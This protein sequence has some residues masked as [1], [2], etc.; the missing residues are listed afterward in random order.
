MIDV[1]K[2]PKGLV[3]AAGSVWVAN[4]GTRT[5]SRINIET[6]RVV[7]TLEVGNGPTEIAV[8]G[9]LLWVA[10]ATDDTIVSIDPQTDLIGER[11]GIGGSPVALVGDHTGLWV[12]T[13]K[14]V[15]GAR[16]DPSVSTTFSPPIPLSGRPSALALDERFAW[17]ATSDGTVTRIERDTNRV[18]STV[19]IGGRPTAIIATDDSVWVSDEEGGV[20]QLDS[21]NPSMSPRRIST[22][23]PIASLAATEGGILVAA[24]ASTASHR[25][26]TLRVASLERYPT[27]PLAGGQDVT[28]L[29]ADGLTGFRRVG[30]TAGATL[31]PDLAVSIPSPSDSGL[32]YTFQLRPNLTYASGEPIRAGDFRRA[33]E[34]SFY[35]P[36]DGCCWGDILFRA[37]VGADACLTEDL[38]PVETCDLTDGVVTDDRTNTVTFRL[39]KP[40]ADLPYKL[41]V[42]PA[43]PVPE[44]V[45]MHEVVDGPFPGAGPYVVTSTSET[46]VRLGRNP[47]FATWDA[48]VRPDGF[49]DEI[50]FDVIEDADQAIS[51]VGNGDIDYVTTLGSTQDAARQFAIQYPDQWH[52]STVGTIFAIMNTS[53]AP[54]DNVDARRAVS[55]AIDRDRMVELGTGPQGAAVTCQ[56]LPP[57]YPGYEPYCPYTEHPGSGRWEHADLSAARAM[58]DSSGTS[59][60]HVVVGPDIFF[61]KPQ[62][63]YLASVLRDLGYD[64]TLMPTYDDFRALRD[65]WAKGNTQITLNGWVPDYL[66]SSTFLGLYTCDGDPSGLSKYCDS[67][68]E[69]AYTHALELQ[70]TDLA[71]AGA[72]WA[73]LDRR[74]ADLALYVPLYNLG[75]DFISARVGNYSFSPSGYPLYDQMWVQ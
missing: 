47:R 51:M 1:G 4:S 67:D 70:E 9:D 52:A 40:D 57:G 58:V 75:G 73:A 56:L 68:Y 41:A 6:G 22:I 26:G 18:N 54:F 62:L 31:L 33:I 24:Q 55:F 19:E 14:A 48:D 66:G 65:E 7:D 17:V 35:L 8:A 20:Y 44:G 46:Q 64:V 53:I 29:T 61:R 72:E 28:A 23:S 43:F 2:A 45:P 21:T 32:T 3:A 37:V 34:R 12:A 59:G 11:V 25:G 30:G 16:V 39:T 69:A 63:E 49:V 13:E 50:V 71:A 74:G 5:V 15:L 42:S 10:N 27:D 36:V 60:A 38:V